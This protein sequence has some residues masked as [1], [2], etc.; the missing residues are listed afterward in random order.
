MGY[1]ENMQTDYTFHKLCKIM[2][3]VNPNFH[4]F[5]ILI[6]NFVNSSVTS[7]EICKYIYRN[8]EFTDSHH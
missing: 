8:H 6:E 2:K 5:V 3:L 1:E 7:L 4:D